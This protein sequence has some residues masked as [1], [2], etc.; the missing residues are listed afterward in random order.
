MSNK[1]TEPNT[2][3]VEAEAQLHHDPATATETSTDRSIEE[4][5]HELQVHQIELE[6]QNEELR[7]THAL[8]EESRDRYIDLYDY[9]PVGYFLLTQNGLIA[10]VNLTAAELLG[11]DRRKLLSRRFAALIAPQDGDQWHLF[12]S[13]T[14]K[15][16]KRVNVA[17]TLKRSNNTEFPVQLDCLCVNS[18]LRIT[19]TDITDI[20]KA[21][22]D[23]CELEKLTQAFTECQQIKVA[24][25]E[26]LNHLQKIASQLPGVVFQFRLYADGNTHFPYAS[27][28][29][30]DIYR[31]SPEDVL[32]DASKVFSLLHPEDYAGV[33]ASMQ[34]SV[35]ELSPWHHEYR[36]KF[37][38]GTVRWLLGNSR[39][40]READGSTLW[41]GFISDVTEIKQS[42]GQ[43]LLNNI[44]LQ[45][46]S[47]GVVITDAKQNI[48]WVNTAFELITGYPLAEIFGQNCRFIQG[49]LTNPQT[50]A[51]IHQALD[52]GTQYA[53]EILNYHR[54]GNSFWNELTIS[55]VF[56]TQGQLT[57]FISTTIDITERKQIE[58]ARR[59]SEFLWKFAIDGSGDGVWDWNIQTHEARYSERWKEMLGYSENDILPTHQ[60]WINR[61]HPSDLSYVMGLLQAYLDGKTAIYTVEY[62]LRCKDD[63]Y[64][65]ILSRGTL[66]TRSED[67]KPLR[68]IGTH[69]DISERIHT[70]ETIQEKKR[71]LSE[72]QRIAH[73]G[74]WSIDLASGYLSCSDELYK[75][76]GVAPEAFGHSMDDFFAI[77]LPEDHA[78]MKAWSS[79]CLNGKRVREV[80][81]RIMRSDGTIRFIR[82]SSELQYDEMNRPLRML[83]SAQDI[84]EQ[85]HREQQD[86]KHLNELAHITRLGLMGEMASGIAHE[87]NQP[88]TAISNYTQVSINLLNTDPPNLLKLNEILLKT[89]QQALRAGQIIHRTREFVQSHKKACSITRINNLIHECINLCTAELKQNNIQ[90]LFELEKDL[91]PVYVDRIQIEQVLINLI[92]NSID[93]LLS[94][95]KKQQHTLIIKSQ[96][97]DNHDIRV[98]VKDNGV[99]ITKEQ[100]QKI[101]TPFYTTKTSG[102]GMGL[103]ISRS[104][105]EAHRGALSFNSELGEGSTFYFTLPAYTV[106]DQELH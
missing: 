54:N 98:S 19:L 95:L 60:E 82:G 14:M 71:M 101:L 27:E 38:D 99:G 59:E 97:M 2:L 58:N 29:I 104:L 31:L 32:E 102:M 75:I 20:K 72:S 93:A 105:I 42:E 15:H 56:D 64:K 53:G 30:R 10:D 18:M 103:S 3:R 63:H 43:L 61:I 6:M 40:Q 74:S 80:D 73:I 9:A 26:A 89:Q 51:E 45:V 57:H 7:R 83:G 24:R 50:V 22:L 100:Q 92:R 76:Y 5:L 77:I 69:T 67:G 84:S 44:A 94:L 46:I 36:V 90:L 4:L 41:H 78:V 85:K 34:K 1:P 23:R 17:L 70:Q 25:E 79:D 88:L 55:P 62:R 48:L 81:F 33:M 86:T 91:P 47:Q 49:P 87:V 35:Q 39:P 12:F 11:M 68:M 66:V 21:E 37:N 106:E 96:L 16:N 8:L 28:A 52:N 13:H 65:W